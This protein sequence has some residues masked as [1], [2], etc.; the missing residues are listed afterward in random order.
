MARPKKLGYSPVKSSV[1]WDITVSRK[2][3]VVWDKYLASIFRV[4][5]AE[6]LMAADRNMVYGVR[7]ELRLIHGGKNKTNVIPLLCFGLRS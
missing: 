2:S 7:P 3:T 4:E 5:E 6:P 1:F